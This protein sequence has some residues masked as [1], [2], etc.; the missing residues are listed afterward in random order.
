MANCRS[1]NTAGG[2][3]RAAP[4]RDGVFCRMHDPEQME[5]VAEARRLGGL[6]RRRESTLAHAFDLPGLAS[7]REVLRLLDIAAFDTLGLENSVARARTLVQ[8][9]GAAI[10]LLEVTSLEERLR[11]LEEHGQRGIGGSE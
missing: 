4:L 8:I 1:L 11:A 5:A 7:P 3:C 9:S 6:R 2:P 10:R